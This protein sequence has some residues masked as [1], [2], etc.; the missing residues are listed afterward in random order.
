MDSYLLLRTT[1]EMI[2]GELRNHGHVHLIQ[3]AN[4][5]G[6]DDYI[7]QVTLDTA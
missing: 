4:S 5:Q 7:L 2:D 6:W 3:L 1:V